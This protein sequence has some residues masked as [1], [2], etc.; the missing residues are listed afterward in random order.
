MELPDELVDIDTQTPQ[1]SGNDSGE[2][3]ETGENE[4]KN[5]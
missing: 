3:T 5:D 1:I 2:E 4:V